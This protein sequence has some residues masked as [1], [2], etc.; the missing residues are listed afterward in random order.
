MG[1]TYNSLMMGGVKLIDEATK[2][3]QERDPSL[4][5]ES[6]LTGPGIENLQRDIP[7]CFRNMLGKKN[8]VI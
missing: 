1:I 2:T 4:L 7:S 3:N 6:R 5:L 8:G